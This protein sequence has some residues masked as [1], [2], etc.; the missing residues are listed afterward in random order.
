MKRYLVAAAAALSVSTA[1]RAD[2]L[3]EHAIT[4]SVPGTKGPVA[5]VKMYNAWTETRH[6]TLFKYALSGAGVSMPDPTE[7]F[8]TFAP[9][10]VPVATQSN[11]G[12]LAYI[13]RLDDDRILAYESASKQYIAEPRR[14]LL[15]KARFDPFVKLAPE[16]SN[17]APPT[18][19]LEQRR[20][21]GSEIRAITKP[22]LDKAL[23]VYFR[24]LSETRDFAGITGRGYRLTALV[25]AGAPTSSG[26]QWARVS[27]EWYVASNLEGDQTISTFQAASLES[28]RDIAY[29]T[30]SMWIN[31]LYPVL[32]QTLPKPLLEAV[33]TLVA[34]QGS[35]RD[36]FVGTPLHLTMTV[37]EPPLARALSGK[38]SGF[39][40]EVALLNREMRELPATVY[41]EPTGYKRLPLDPYFKKMKDAEKEASGGMLGL[42]SLNSGSES[43]MTWE[44]WQDYTR[45]LQSATRR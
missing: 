25:N 20:R 30:T 16:L 13:T 15:M 40:L 3:W 18:L 29:P 31:E 38:D 39:N 34:F 19:S 7:V 23:K 33:E 14:A 44:A 6:R 2:V 45:A 37:T 4:V 12:S 5:R 11:F 41:G 9:R 10:Q 1:A 32:Y 8:S 21:Y 17:T 42:S 43:G 26:A 36:G 24:P 22:Y 35:G 28:I 27:I